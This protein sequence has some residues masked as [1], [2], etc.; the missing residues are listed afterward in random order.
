[1][2][3][4]R[5]AS[6]RLCAD[7]AEPIPSRFITHFEQAE[8]VVAHTREY[9]AV[10]STRQGGACWIWW[11]KSGIMMEDPGVCAVFPHHVRTG[12]LADNR[13]K[14]EVDGTHVTCGGV[15][16]R[17][18]SRQGRLRPSLGR[19]LRRLTRPRRGD[20]DT[21]PPLTKAS[22]LPPEQRLALAHDYFRREVEFGEDFIELTDEL[23]CRVA[24]QIA[25]GIIHD[26]RH[27]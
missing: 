23:I 4:S 10:V 16:R 9:R 15:L 11:S 12:G 3:A 1:M 26:N 18:V 25:V 20:A 24:C 17:L 8:L 22:P 6:E 5:N 14:S 19:W 7:I 21:R 13:N 2:L 27:I